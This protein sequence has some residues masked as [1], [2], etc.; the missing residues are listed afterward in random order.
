[1]GSDVIA[2]DIIGFNVHQCYCDSYQQ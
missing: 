1:V 2:L